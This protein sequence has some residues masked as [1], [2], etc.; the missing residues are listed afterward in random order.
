MTM[1]MRVDWKAAA[2]AWRLDIPQAGLERI[3][4]RLDALD[5]IFRPLADGLKPDHEPACAFHANV[6]EA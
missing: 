5:E 3:A 1:K 6:E 2:E 4:P